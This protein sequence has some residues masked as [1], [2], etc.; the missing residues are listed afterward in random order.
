MNRHTLTIEISMRCESDDPSKS[1]NFVPTN[2]FGE[3]MKKL[4]LDY[5]T[6]DVTFA[7]DG[8]SMCAH[9]A[10]LKNCAPTLFSL[11]KTCGKGK[12]VPI[13]GVDVIIFHI[14]L[15]YVYGKKLPAKELEENARGL[16]DAADRFGVINLKVEAETM[17]VSNFKFTVHNVIEQLLYADSKNLA[18]LK[19]AAMNFIYKNAVDVLSTDSF[20]TIPAD[21]NI[22]SELL[23]VVAMKNA[24]G[25]AKKEEEDSGDERSNKKTVPYK[26]MSVTDLRWQLSGRDLDVDGSRE[27]LIARLEDHDSNKETASGKKRKNEEI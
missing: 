17:Y 26:S 4:F 15:E 18:L 21:R 11:C 8:T 6:G 14:L 20:K 9:L 27:M 2:P 22:L 5:E 19:E 3:S 10:V 7:I 16:I 12:D 1:V 13:T 24:A 23:S 25:S